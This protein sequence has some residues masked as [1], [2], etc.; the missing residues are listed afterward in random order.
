LFLDFCLAMVMAIMSGLV[1][2]VAARVGIGSQQGN[3]TRMLAGVS[4]VVIKKFSSSNYGSLYWTDKGSDADFDGTTFKVP[5]MDGWKPLGDVF[6]GGERTSPYIGNLPMFAGDVV[7]PTGFAW[8]WSDGGSGADQDVTVWQPMPPPGYFCPANAVTMDENPPKTSDYVCLP[9]RCLD[10][11]EITDKHWT[12]RGSGADY[13]F[14]AFQSPIHPAYFIGTLSYPNSIWGWYA[15]NMA[16]GGVDVVHASIFVLERS[17][18]VHNPSYVQ[19]S[20]QGKELKGATHSSY[21]EDAIKHFAAQLQARLV[22]S[23]TNVVEATLSQS[24]Q[25]KYLW[26][27][28]SA[29]DQTSS[30]YTDTK[31]NLWG[32][33]RVR[34]VY[35]YQVK[36][37]Y[38]LSDGGWLEQRSEPTTSD[39]P[40]I[41]AI[42][43]PTTT[44]MTTTTTMCHDDRP[45][46]CKQLATSCNGGWFRWMV[47]RCCRMTCNTCETTDTCPLGPR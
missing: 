28:Q 8:V 46:M 36:I 47:T 6:K 43:T 18:G 26:L 1:V 2:C 12:D 21:P 7:N 32:G 42:T 38:T 39:D 10:R 33:T 19:R 24:L 29:G 37:K 41:G 23:T 11:V 27:I 20:F 40:F 35:V 3:S 44:T 17:Q 22:D 13:D 16:C 34:P 31:C 45:A 30:S 14:T 25:Q 4:N 15:L 9:A 5:P